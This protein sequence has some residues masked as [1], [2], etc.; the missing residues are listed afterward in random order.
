MYLSMVDCGPG[1]FAIWKRIR[2]ETAEVIS[3]VLEEV[4]STVLEE[5]FLERGPVTDV[6]MDN[7]R[8]FLSATL[9]EMLDK[10]G[11]KCFFRAAYRLSSNGI[12]ERHHRTIKVL[13]ERSRI[14]LQEAMSWYNLSPKTGLKV[15][16]VPQNAIFKYE[17]R[18][19]CDVPLAT[20]QGEAT[21]QIGDKVWVKPLSG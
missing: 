7:G 16:S 6:L 3:T 11:V 17:W 4:F 12:V 8:A 21:V 18:H 9:K 1:R 2:G 13:T 14:S 10:W 5:V 20:E 19:P 15:D